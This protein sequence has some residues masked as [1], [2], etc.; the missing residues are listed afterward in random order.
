[1]LGE[2]LPEDT[3]SRLIEC[4]VNESNLGILGLLNELKR[5]GLENIP[6]KNLERLNLLP[7]FDPALFIN[8]RV[9]YLV[10]QRTSPHS[11]PDFQWDEIMCMVV[12]FA[13]RDQSQRKEEFREVSDRDIITMGAI[14]YSQSVGAENSKLRE[15]GPIRKA[16]TSML[17]DGLE[18][19]SPDNYFTETSQREQC[20]AMLDFLV[21]SLG[22]EGP[23]G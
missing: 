12:D 22:K 3:T 15:R 20:G 21:Q 14:V 13:L 5:H 1:M 18:P 6:R 7:R 9:N 16:V 8:M 23:Q 17:T 19:M 11:S 2:P 10:D 4:G